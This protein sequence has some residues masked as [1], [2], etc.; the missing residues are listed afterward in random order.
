MTTKALTTD[1]VRLGAVAQQEGERHPD[2]VLPDDG[3]RDDEEQGQPRPTAR[4]LAAA[5]Q[6]GVVVEP[7]ELRVGRPVAR[8]AA[9]VSD[10]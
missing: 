10:P 1:P 7:D 8:Q 5:Q 2:D 3:R 9:L 6:S 4:S